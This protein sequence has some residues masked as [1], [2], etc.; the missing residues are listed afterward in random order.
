[1]SV[2]VSIADVR[3]EVD[4]VAELDEVLDELTAS[5]EP[6]L[7]ELTG[8][9]AVMNV[10]VG[11]SDAAV[12]LFRDADGRPW[13]ARSHDGWSTDT[14]ANLEFARNGTPHRFF[15]H[16]AVA[17]AEMREAAREFVRT[18]GAKPSVFMWVAEGIGADT[19]DGGEGG[20]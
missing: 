2:Q 13:C 8:R 18:P 14:G 4:S 17:P 6:T 19:S 15:A 7:V 10:G 11:R 20:P 9:S 12:A 3:R 1:V 16:A 5:G